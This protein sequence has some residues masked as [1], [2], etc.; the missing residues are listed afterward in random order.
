MSAYAAL[1]GLKNFFVSKAEA[2][3]I[4]NATFCFAKLVTAVLIGCSILTTS[5]QFFGDPIHCHLDTKHL[6]LKVFESYC[7]M[8]ETYTL[9]ATNDSHLDDAK[10]YGGSIGHGF[11]R[12]DQEHV[13]HS[14]YQWVPLVLVLQAALCYLPWYFWK[15][16]EGGMIG[17]LL[18]GLSS[19]PLTEAP[20]DDQVATLGDFLL[21]HRGWFNTTALKL[22]L[23]QA[24]SFFSSLGQLY[25]MDLF[26]GR[27][28]LHFGA[29]IFNYTRLRAALVEVFPRVVMCSMDLFGLS[30]SLSKVSG[31]CTLPVNIVNEKIYLILWF[32]F[33]AHTI[34]SLLQLIRQASLLMVSLRPCLT[35]GLTSSLTSPR[36]VRQ[37]LVRGSYGDT[38]LLQ[39][40]AANCDSAQFAALV[41]LLVRGQRLDDSYV[42][43]QLALGKKNDLFQMR[44]ER[45]EADLYSKQQDLLTV[46]PH[47]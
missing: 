20:V 2:T 11:T 44:E 39:L 47:K 12:E 5:K 14:Y 35:P 38:V 4:S 32:A 27:R 22:L 15:K 30:N 46:T 25:V 29:N 16:T 3:D 40:I 7:F 24:A 31:M 26:L 17:K 33:L 8:E 34:V 37:L 45:L 41:Q 43:Q 10:L 28:F 6:S 36:Q 13:F 18:A 1:V 42:S 9:A 19:D 23:C 21:T